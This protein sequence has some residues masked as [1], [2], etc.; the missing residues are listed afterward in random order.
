MHNQS[1]RQIEKACLNTGFFSIKGHG[2]Q[3]EINS[4]LLVCKKF[5]SL[6]LSK[7]LSLAP[8]KWNKKN[9]NIYR[10]YF[11]STVNGKE[12]LDLGDPKLNSS[13]KKIVSKHLV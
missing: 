8:K 6:P 11:P 3:S 9:L 4:T 5:F 7:K 2:I 1:I 13:M 12:G 10:G